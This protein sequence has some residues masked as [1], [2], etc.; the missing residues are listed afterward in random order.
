M[1]LLNFTEEKQRIIQKRLSKEFITEI[2][3]NRFEY[4]IGK[5]NLNKKA[6]E[7]YMEMIV[8]LSMLEDEGKVW[9]KFDDPRKAY[10]VHEVRIHWRLTE[11]EELPIEVTKVKDIINP[12][13]LSNGDG[14]VNIEPNGNW[15]FY[16]ELYSPIEGWDSYKDKYFQ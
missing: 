3:T 12:M 11:Y 6:Y 1:E 9:F 7:A 8:T 2:L 10:D 5:Y 15:V 14:L 16:V 4:P 13:L